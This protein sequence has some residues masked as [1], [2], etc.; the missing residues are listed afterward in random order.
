MAIEYVSQGWR[1]GQTVF[2]D[3]AGDLWLLDGFYT[4]PVVM[5]KPIGRGEECRATH[6][7]RAKWNFNLHKVELQPPLHARNESEAEDAH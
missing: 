3:N 6:P 2:I 5:L 7:A 1:S 4:D